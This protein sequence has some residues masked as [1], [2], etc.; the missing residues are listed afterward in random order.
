L[1]ARIKKW[2]E[3]FAP[4]QNNNNTT[5][6]MKIT[7]KLITLIGS[8]AVAASATAIA[9]PLNPTSA[10]LDDKLRET[11]QRFAEFQGSRGKHIPLPV[12][13]NCHGIVIMRTVK[14]GLGV[15]AETGGGVAL[16]KNE[17][18]EWSAPAFV[19]NAEGSWGLQIGAE[20]A[21]I[22][23]VLMT[24]DSLKMLKDGASVKLGVDLAATA[25]PI[26]VGADFDTAELTS[27]VLIYSNAKGAFAGATI[28][29]GGVVGA[30]KRNATYYGKTLPDILFGEGVKATPVG[31]VL[32]ERLKS[33]SAT[34]SE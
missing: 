31:Q 3:Q 32:I 22:I 28:K 12:L 10:K 18:G 20:S 11:T 7:N 23:I 15:G 16:V 30:K 29:G 5:L 21:D 33:L 13:S 24:Q 9:N 25:G 2:R 17:A 8:F 19:V 6:Q 26:D 27:P 14:A 1:E 34:A 4:Y